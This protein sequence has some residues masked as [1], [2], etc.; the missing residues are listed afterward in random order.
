MK[1]AYKV[2]IVDSDPSDRSLAALLLERELPDAAIVAP[3]D[4]MALAEMLLTSAPQLAILAAEQAWS[5]LAEM[6]A[7]IRRHTPATAVLVYGHESDIVARVLNPG[8]VCDGLVRKSSA[9]FLN[10]GTLVTQVRERG[11][12]KASVEPAAPAGVPAPAS[13][14]PA[15]SADPVVPPSPVRAPAPPLAPSASAPVHA[16]PAGAATHA[17]NDRSSHEMRDIAM[18]FSH[19]LREPLQQIMRLAARAEVSAGDSATVTQTVPRLLECASRANNMLDGMLEYLDLAAR[20][21]APTKVDLN[22]CLSEA[23]DNLRSA[24]AESGA[25]ISAEHL[26]LTMGDEYQLLHLFQ[27]LLSN[28]IKFRGRERPRVRITAEPQGDHW[29]LRF[30]DNGIGIA[31]PFVERVFEMG[32]RLHT[33]EEYPGLGLGLALSRRI[34]ER[35]GGL[36]WVESGDDSGSTFCV[37]LPATA[38]D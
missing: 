25:D 10:L 35:H 21:T 24:I 28:A 20:D 4:P 16:V 3:A 2:L 13:P 5:G 32:Q 1:T 12:I 29:L 34:V 37:L 23:I 36:I 33:R 19:D 8:L 18:L 6:I 26:P 9:G 7:T 22:V 38:T 27:N 31:Q 15:A 11:Q 30:R 17:A 14:A